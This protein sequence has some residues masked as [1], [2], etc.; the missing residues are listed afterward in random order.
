MV[1]WLGRIKAVGEFMFVRII[2]LLQ[3]FDAFTAVSMNM[4]ILENIACALSHI[5]CHG[6]IYVIRNLFFR[7][8][9]IIIME[10]DSGRTV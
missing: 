4:C 6:Y 2:Y 3:V 7:M 8:R 9:Q 1:C 5:G 10:N